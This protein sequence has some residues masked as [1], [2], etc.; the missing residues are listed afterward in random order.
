MS[1]FFTKTL[2]SLLTAWFIFAGCNKHDDKPIAQKIDVPVQA[3]L[4]KGPAPI[5]YEPLEEKTSVS[6]ASLAKVPRGL[7]KSVFYL[8]KEASFDG[9]KLI[10]YKR[11]SL[12][13]MDCLPNGREQ[14]GTRERAREQLLRSFGLEDS[15][16]SGK[17]FHDT[18]ADLRIRPYFNPI[19]GDSNFV[20]IYSI[21]Y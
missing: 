12:P 4:L 5:S 13:E 9:D 8:N 10:N 11:F 1:K 14:E 7:D 21:K 20:I 2:C 18:T 6:Q 17:I 16:F 15:I 19:S 3:Q